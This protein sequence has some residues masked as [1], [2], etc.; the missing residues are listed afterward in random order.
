MEPK[1]QE[2][3]PPTAREYSFAKSTYHYR[4]ET[5]ELL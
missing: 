4:F 5:E 2:K 1:E 3:K